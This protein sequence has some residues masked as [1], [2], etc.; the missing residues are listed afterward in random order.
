METHASIKLVSTTVPFC[1]AKLIPLKKT[2]LV[3]ATPMRVA[4]ILSGTES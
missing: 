2:M 4:L 1:T 3:M